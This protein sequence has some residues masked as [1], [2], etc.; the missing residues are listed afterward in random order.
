MFGVEAVGGC[1]KTRPTISLLM[2]SCQGRERT[3][4]SLALHDEWGVNFFSLC[5]PHFLLIILLVMYKWS[6]VSFNVSP[7]PCGEA[8][9]LGMSSH[10]VKRYPTACH[11]IG[12]LKA[13]HLAPPDAW[14]LSKAEGEQHF[15][16][17]Q[18][19][20]GS[21]PEATVGDDLA[22]QCNHGFTAGH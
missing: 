5:P 16:L 1:L 19:H 15:T 2:G 22:V 11:S 8:A 14:S 18:S 9:S 10:K 21:A 7:F 3:Q 17:L 4:F 13:E 20:Y 6:G 12:L